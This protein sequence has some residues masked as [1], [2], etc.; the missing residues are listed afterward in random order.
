MEE[1]LPGDVDTCSALWEEASRPPRNVTFF[2]LRSWQGWST[3]WPSW[4]EVLHVY[5]PDPSPILFL[6]FF[7]QIHNRYQSSVTLAWSPMCLN[8]V[9][10]CRVIKTHFHKCTNAGNFWEK[11]LKDVRILS[12]SSLARQPLVEPDLL[13]KLCP[14]VSVDGDLLPI[15]D[16]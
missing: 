12:S 8:S 16:L 10:D 11:Y 14:F 15:L 9:P 13:K 7:L 6:K 2:L 1:S 4:T 5:V 3:F